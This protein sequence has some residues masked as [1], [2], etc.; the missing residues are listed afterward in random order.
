MLDTFGNKA[1]ISLRMTVAIGA[2]PVFKSKCI[3]YVELYIN[4]D[5]SYTPKHN[6]RP[7][8]RKY[9]DHTAQK[10]FPG[11]RCL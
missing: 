3:C 8:F 5:S 2:N 6:N 4:N 10:D 9:F 1:F 11:P 7:E